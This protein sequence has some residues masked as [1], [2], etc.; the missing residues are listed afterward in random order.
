MPYDPSCEV[1]TAWDLGFG[2]ATAIWWLQFVG[3]ELRW[4]DYYESCGEQ[5]DHYVSLVKSKPYNYSTHYLP[6]DGGHGNIRGESVSIQL[7]QMGLQ[8]TVRS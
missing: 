6:H 2:N 5:L 4:L 8:N 7:N 1:F 3:R